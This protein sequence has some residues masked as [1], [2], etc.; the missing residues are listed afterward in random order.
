MTPLSELIEECE[1]I[2]EHLLNGKWKKGI[3][4]NDKMEGEE[5]DTRPTKRFH[6]KAQFDPWTTCRE[7]R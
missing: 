5:I 1:V 3:F 4:E 2:P 7:D 6:E